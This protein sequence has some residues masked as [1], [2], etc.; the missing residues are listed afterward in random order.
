M[1]WGGEGLLALDHPKYL[2]RES[3]SVAKAAR[4]ICR[5]KCCAKTACRADFRG[6]AGK[7]ERQEE[8][9]QGKV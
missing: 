3:T 6:W 4:A 9:G 8:G 7:G 2:K 1:W 5:H